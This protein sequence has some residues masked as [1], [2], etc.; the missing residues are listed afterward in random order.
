MPSAYFLS[1]FCS[2]YFA[3]ACAPQVGLEPFDGNPLQHTYFMSMFRESVEKKIEDPKVRLNWLMQYTRGEA[4]DLIK[5]F[6]KDTPEYKYNNGMAVLHRQYGNIHTL[7]LSYRWEVRQMVPLKAGDATA[8]RKLLNFPIKCQT[9][10]VDGLDGHY[11]PLDTPEII[12]T[13]LPKFPL[14]LQ[15]RWNHNTLQLRRKYSK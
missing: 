8:F 4:K 13:D 7:L 15:D 3:F 14:H 10:E 6:L 11:N 12:C 9:I 1:S 2:S 5:N